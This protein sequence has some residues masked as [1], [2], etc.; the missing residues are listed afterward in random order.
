[1]NENLLKKSDK[2]TI[3][4]GDLVWILGQWNGLDFGIE[5]KISGP[6]FV[7]KVLFRQNT[8]ARVDVLNSENGEERSLMASWLYV[9]KEQK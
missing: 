1:M 8:D 2:N 3:K 6:F 4:T 9:L 7:K 5:R